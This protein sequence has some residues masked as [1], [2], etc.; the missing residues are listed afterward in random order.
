MSNQLI[1][2]A[3]LIW[4]LWPIEQAVCRG[5]PVLLQLWLSAL[6]G[7]SPISQVYSSPAVGTLELS[8]LRLCYSSLLHPLKSWKIKLPSLSTLPFSRQQTLYFCGVLV[9]MSLSNLFPPF[10]PLPASS[11]SLPKAPAQ[12]CRSLREGMWHHSMEGNTNLHSLQP[13]IP[14]G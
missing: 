14:K 6:A 10:Q 5:A 1:Q 3:A 12:I 11:S 8:F 2:T 13:G 7:Q 4:L 9:H